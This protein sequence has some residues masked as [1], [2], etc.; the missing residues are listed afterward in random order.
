M[1]IA[2]FSLIIL[3]YGSINIGERYLY[4]DSM[5]M[6]KIDLMLYP[7]MIFVF[8]SNDIILIFTLQY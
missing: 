8:Y 7:S 2:L 1:L 3:Y 4:K 6:S 5:K